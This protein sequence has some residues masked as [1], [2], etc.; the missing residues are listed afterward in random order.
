MLYKAGAIATQW[1]VVKANEN[2]GLSGDQ[3]LT[4]AD[5]VRDEMAVGQ[6]VGANGVAEGLTEEEARSIKSML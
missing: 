6:T 4:W 1:L 2:R 5:W 3:R